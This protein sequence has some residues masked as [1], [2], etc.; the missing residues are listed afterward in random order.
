M[1]VSWLGKLFL[2]AMSFADIDR[3][4][5]DNAVRWK[6]VERRS[7]YYSE[8]LRAMSANGGKRVTLLD[9]NPLATR[10]FVY[11][12]HEEGR[13]LLQHRDHKLAEAVLRAGILMDGFPHVERYRVLFLLSLKLWRR[14]HRSHECRIHG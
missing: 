5:F 11:M 9:R 4:R 13:Q 10:A 7:V 1:V 12:S 2:R 6:Q 8:A 3:I 14:Y